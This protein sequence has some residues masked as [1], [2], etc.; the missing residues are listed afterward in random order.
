M[1][2]ILKNKYLW[3]LIPVA[4]GL[5]LFV[6]I[7]GGKKSD[8]KIIPL[9]AQVKFDGTRLTVTNRDT[10][11]YVNATLALNEY[12]KISGVNLKAGENYEIWPAEFIHYNGKHFSSQQVP[13]QFSI[14]C[15]TNNGK[16]GF[17][18]KKLR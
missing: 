3:I 12:Y 9:R 10:I 14:W 15:E 17:Y 18:S 8:H 1:K 13:V 5:I 16:N 2:P 11:D 4:A 6:I 7:N